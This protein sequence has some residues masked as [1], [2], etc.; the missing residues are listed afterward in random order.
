MDVKKLTELAKTK[1]FW[2]RLAGGGMIAAGIVWMT[3][4]PGLLFIGGIG[5]L[6]LTDD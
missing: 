3:G 6:L 4:T 1:D 2:L 5:C